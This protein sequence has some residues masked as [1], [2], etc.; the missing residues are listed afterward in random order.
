[1]YVPGVSA[2]LVNL[3]SRDVSQSPTCLDFHVSHLVDMAFPSCFSLLSE[4]K[5]I[6]HYMCDRIWRVLLQAGLVSTYLHEKATLGQELIFRGV[7]GDFTLDRAAKRIPP[8]GQSCTVDGDV[9]QLDGT[10]VQHSPLPTCTVLVS[11]SLKMFSW[12]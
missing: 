1:M 8:A 3:V 11:L 10:C 9:R 7:D 6:C 2:H 5:V 4:R 12:V